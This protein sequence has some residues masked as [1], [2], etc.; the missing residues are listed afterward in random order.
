MVNKETSFFYYEVQAYDIDKKSID[1]DK[2]FEKRE[3]N[4]H[5]ITIKRKN[6]RI[7]TLE[8]KKNFENLFYGRIYRSRSNKEHFCIKDR[9]T[10]ILSDIIG[11]GETGLLINDV[12][13]FGMLI[14]KGK[15]FVLIEQGFQ[16]PG[17][18]VFL[19]YLTALTK[20][21]N[22]SYKHISVVKEKDY[23]PLKKAFSKNLFS[24]SM[25]I[26]KHA[27]LPEGTPVE[28]F[29]KRMC[30]TKEYVIDFEIRLRNPTK[31]AT[32]MKVKQPLLEFLGLDKKGETL[33]DLLKID[34]PS[35][36]TRFQIECFDENP[37]ESVHF[38]ILDYYEKIVY[39]LDK[40][41]LGNFHSLGKQLCIHLQ[42]KA[43]EL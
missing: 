20:D 33:E 38:N 3:V 9:E 17:I 10:K 22:F 5:N 40:N 30:L 1:F 6:G 25:K 16:Y 19:E 18:G 13:T 14:H 39:T 31:K 2:I 8:F 15:L 32:Y 43:K 28:E 24:L 26:K 23:K 29:M 7:F 42:Q 12:V 21:D 34:F 36:L 37:K 41:N 27:D 35:L 4:N 11:D